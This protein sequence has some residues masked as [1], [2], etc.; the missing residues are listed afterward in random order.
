MSQ[1]I[2]S[3]A[4][5]ACLGRNE[6]DCRSHDS[7]IPPVSRAVKNPWRKKSD[8]PAVPGPGHAFTL[9]ELL[10]VIAI[11]AI[12]AALLL[13]VLASAKFRAKVSNCTS[14]YRQWGVAVN[15]YSNDDASGRFPRFDD[16]SINNTW[17]LDPRMISSLGRYGLTVPMWYCPVRPNEFVADDAWC[18]S[19]TG[20]GHPMTSL[21][22]LSRAVTRVFGAQLAVCYHAWWVP[23]NGSAAAGGFYPVGTNGMAWPASMADPNAS[24]LPILTDRAASPVTGGSPDP[25]ALGAGTGHPLNGHLKNMNILYG[26]AHVELHDISE[27][28]MRFQG[29]YYNFY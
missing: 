16:G 26:D 13:P 15:M 14:S 24:L 5:G 17:D 19:A 21:V 9:I 20:L 3:G 27:V 6:L 18:Q 7:L 2:K 4:V 11:I 10:V 29:N 23:R 8:R 1:C 25:L 12:L 28:Q 22:D